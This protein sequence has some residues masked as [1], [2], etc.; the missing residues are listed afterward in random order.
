MTIRTL[1]FVCLFSCQ[2]S[3][4]AQ[5]DYPHAHEP[6]GNVRQVYDGALMPDI[7]VNTFR[8]IDRLFSTRTV[9][10]G[11]TVYPLPRSER[12]LTSVSFKSD[13]ATYDLFDYV[14]LNRVSGL[15]AI[16]DGE[17]VYETYQLGN[18]EK[19]RWM[20]MSIVKSITAILVGAAIKDGHIESIDDEVT[21]YVTELEGS[22]YEGVSVRNLLQMASGVQWNE[23]YTDAESDRRQLLEAQISQKP[24]SMLGVMAGLSRAATPG[25]RWNYSTGETQVVAALVAAA[26][27]RPLSD[28]L[29]QKIWAK[30]G[31]ES[32]A[33]WWLESPNGIE[34]GGSGF[35]ATLRDYARFGLFL[36]KGGVAGGE[37]ILP[38]GWVEAASS[39]NQIGGS[40]VDYGYMLWPI[41]ESE[42]TIHNGAFEARGIFGQKIYIN[43]RE[44]VVIAIWSAR[45]KP[46]GKTTVADRNFYAAVCEA[47]R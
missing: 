37:E 46:L 7:Q 20:S 2:S 11:S 17:I 24:G 45:P 43:P 41:P 21:K 28:Y 14:S 31:M 18:N 36:L 32:D 25:T 12:P 35:S 9:R 16:K 34:V 3:V 39:P 4:V 40:M 27:D 15:I 6:I 1:L 33:S 22:A 19:S 30:F 44:D 42:N 26:V 38:A 5:T 47:V 23:T 10:R 13:G 8:N 29:S